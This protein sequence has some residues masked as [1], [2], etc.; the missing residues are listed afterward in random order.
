MDF[1]KYSNKAKEVISNAQ[2]LAL[3]KGHQ[4]FIPEHVLKSMLEDSDN[5]TS[6]LII[7]ASGNLDVVKGGLAETL[8]KIPSVSSSGSPNVYF[9]QEMAILDQSVKRVSKVLGDEF[10]TLEAFL[11]AMFDGKLKT[12]RILQKAGLILPVVSEI[13]SELRKGKTADS[14]EAEDKFDALKKYA[15]DLTE[16]ASAGKIDPVIGR[17]DEIRRTIQVLSRR[18]KNNP[19]LIGEPGVGKTAI[20]EGLAQRIAAGDVPESLKKKKIMSLDLGALIGGAKYRGEFEERLKAVINEIEHAD[21]EVILFID[22]LH[23]LVGAG[24]AEGSMDASNLLKPALARGLLHCVGATTLDEYRLHIEKDPAL[25]RRF[26]SIYVAEPTIEDSVTILR[27]LKE[28]YE[29]HHAIRIS[30]SAII[31]AC[32]LSQRY[33]TDRFLP[34][35]AIDLI[36]EAASKLRMEIDSKPEEMDE[37]ERKLIQLRIEAETLKKEKDDNSKTRLQAINDEIK[38]LDDKLSV[39]SSK[40]EAEKLRLEKEKDIK[41]QLEKANYELEKATRDGDLA[42]AG[43]LSYSVIPELT[44]QAENHNIGAKDSLIKE[45]INEADIALVISKVTGIPV[46]KMLAADK[47]KYLNIADELGKKVIGQEEAITAI[48]NALKRSKAGLNNPNK[49]LGSFLFIGPTGVGKTELSKVLAESLFNEKSALLRF[50]MSEFMEKH[51]VS[52]LIGS[53]PGYVG[54]EDAGSLTEAIRRRPYQVVLFDEVE[55]AHPDVFNIML[56]V[57]D[58]GILTDSH[59]RKVNFANTLIIMTSNLGSVKLNALSNEQSIKDIE[60]DIMNDVRAFF[61]PEFINRI[62]EIILFHKLRYQHMDKII[63]IKMREMQTKLDNYQIEMQ[64]DDKAKEYLAMNGYDAKFGARPLARLIEREI[65]NKIA[66]GLLDGTIAEK[67][68]IKVSEDKGE[69]AIL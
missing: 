68:K 8:A 63:D 52:K 44:A 59:G 40:W 41:E 56:Q 69:I 29:M 5:Y 10:I 16:L 35:K 36:D 1:S 42:R 67:S 38:I 34:D 3:S 31:A 21:H 32:N 65:T 47:Q 6:N 2:G 61:K 39:F 55:K 26:Q 62:D 19:V 45:S 9:S 20:I 33:I 54:Y 28:K 24:K 57:L 49:P 27:G 25:A 37:L 17:D 12:S 14:A 7:S 58:D 43:E 22:E 15:K 11:L 48:A 64:L 60:D 51:A 53:P 23:N 13:I 50:D 18:T 66:T 30:D 46:E 4:N